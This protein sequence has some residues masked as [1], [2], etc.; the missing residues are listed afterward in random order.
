MNNIKASFLPKFSIE[1][2]MGIFWHKL[3]INTDMVLDMIFNK[4][5]FDFYSNAQISYHPGITQFY[6]IW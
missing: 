2:S 6:L 5:I 4:T 1:I 3:G